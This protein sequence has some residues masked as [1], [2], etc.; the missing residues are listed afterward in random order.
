[1]DRLGLFRRFQ[2][3][4]RVRLRPLVEVALR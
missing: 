3:R 4:W 1:L 2:H